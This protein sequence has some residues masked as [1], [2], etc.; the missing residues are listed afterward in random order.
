[1]LF[2]VRTRNDI[3]QLSKTVTEAAS[4]TKKPTSRPYVSI[5][6]KAPRKLRSIINE[7]MIMN[8]L[9]AG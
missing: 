3:K 8:G 9:G 7:K 2:R 4:F 5:R 6:N 1:M